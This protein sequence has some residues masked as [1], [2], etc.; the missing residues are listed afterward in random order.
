MTANRVGPNDP[1]SCGSAKKF[2]ECCE[3]TADRVAEYAHV[4]DLRRLGQ[5]LKATGRPQ[6]STV[7]NGK[8]IRAVG[9]RL[10]AR[11]LEET[12]HE[13]ILTLLAPIFGG[14]WYDAEFKKPLAERHIAAQWY[15]H[16][17]LWQKKSETNVKID[18]AWNAITDGPT[19]AIMQLA[20]DV[21]LLLHCSSLPKPVLKRLRDRDAFQG[22]R[23]EVAVAA[24][25]ARLGYTIAWED[26]K[27]T[28]RHCEFIATNPRTGDRIGVE[29]KSRRRSGVLHEPV[30]Y[31]GPVK[32]RGD[33]G[34]LL[35]KAL[36]QKPV[37]TPFII[38]VDLNLPAT[39]HL[40]FKDKPWFADIQ[41][42]ILQMPPP[43]PAVPDAANA[44]IVTNFS[45]HYGAPGVQAPP[46]EYAVFAPKYMKDPLKNAAAL[47]EIA[48]VLQGYGQI[49][50]QERDPQAAAPMRG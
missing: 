23:Y 13:F 35:D 42:L 8:R 1:C 18:G 15:Y 41:A 47:T 25:F 5:A 34:G 21:Y 48:G 11:P 29:A 36:S 10:Y 17:R 50:D 7:Y 16:H 26:E 22:V 32:M 38:F 24:I 33:I 27:Q 46:R 43:T 12:F 28:T 3:I 4:V 19:Q 9:S 2:N 6:I 31:E 30:K 20:Y 40:E 45:S 39:A 44:I 49:P 37:G 14:K